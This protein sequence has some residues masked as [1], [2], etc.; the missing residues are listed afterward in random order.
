M[1]TEVC[2]QVVHDQ[3]KYKWKSFYETLWRGHLRARP[4]F[5]GWDSGLQV[6]RGRA[7]RGAGPPQAA[8]RAALA[9][10]FLL[11]P[12]G[13]ARRALRAGVGRGAE[14]LLEAASAG[15]RPAYFRLKGAETQKRS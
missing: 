13:G 11:R 6:G 10:Q 2:G 1:N 3:H 5:C 8:A 15:G 9:L 14:H 12:P 7:R 4:G